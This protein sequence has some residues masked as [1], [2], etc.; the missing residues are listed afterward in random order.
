MPFLRLLALMVTA[1]FIGAT[2]VAQRTEFKAMTWNIL[3]GGRDDGKE[4]GP[5]RVI[6]VIKASG[7]DLVAMQE[8]YGSGELISKALGYHF[9]ARG[10]NVSIHSKFPILEDISVFQEFKCVGA[11]IE[12]PN[13]AKIAFYSIWLPYDKEIWEEG[14]RNSSNIA[15]MLS[16][17]A[18]S[19]T[20]LEKIR[21]EIAARLSDP[22]YA[23]VPVVIAGDFN[24]MSHLD[25][26]A[27]AHDQY[28]AV[29]DWPTSRVLVDEGFRDAFRELHPTVNRMKDRTWSPRFDKQEQDRIDFC[30]YKGHGLEAKESEVIQ[31]H[32][33]LFPSDHAALLTKF[34]YDPKAKP[35][36][37]VRSR[38]LSYNI[39]HC[40]GMDDSVQVARTADKIRSLD[41]DI[42]G[43][44]EVDMNV[45]RSGP[46]N[47]PAELG[48][49][50]GMHAA[51]GAFMDYDGGQYGMAILSRYPLRNVRTVPLPAGEEPRVALVAEVRLPSGEALTIV[52]V[53]FDWIDDD[54]SR[55]AQATSLAEFLRGLKTPYVLLGDFNDTPGSRTI[56]LFQSLAGEAKKPEKDRLTFSSTKPEKEIDFIFFSPA[57]RWQARDT[58]VLTE[59]LISDHRPLITELTLKSTKK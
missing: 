8:T 10:T 47:Q 20:D 11:L 35:M 26:T 55:F 46:V 25:Y 37:E 29:I 39:R 17:C 2:A 44:Q 51:F 14:T 42:V 43:L 40:R 53:H 9:L 50:L 28:K 23:G 33:I 54:K 24:S 49:M 12:L 6:E 18:S 36:N 15:E 7:A 41:P 21:T 5:Q 32:S 30:Y 19:A 16:A 1:L 31:E 34:Q 3:H 4:I 27:V 58:R 22:K 13:K 56:S 52:N 59:K 48:R 57:E 38:V 45:N